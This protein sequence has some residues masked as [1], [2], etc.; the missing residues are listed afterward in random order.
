MGT[1][2]ITSNATVTYS[3]GGKSYTEKVADAAIKYGTVNLTAT[4]DRGSQ[5][6]QCR[7]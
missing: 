6:R 3:A 7:R 5:G 1:K 2:N 4:P